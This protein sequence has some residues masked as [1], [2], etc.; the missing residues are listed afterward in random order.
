MDNSL[1]SG[2]SSSTTNKLDRVLGDGPMCHCSRGTKLTKSWTDANPGRRFFR[3]EAHGFISWAD[4]EEASGWQKVSLIEARDQIRRCNG[5]ISRLKASITEL[6]RGLFVAGDVS[7]TTSA[8]SQEGIDKEHEFNRLREE[9]LK[10]TERE[11]MYRQFLVLS[12]GGFFIVTA[13][14]ITAMKH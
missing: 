9:S 5:E 3:C 1:S 4:R 10:S 14:I 11:K 6:N 2:S 13:I 12:W 8:V 7:H